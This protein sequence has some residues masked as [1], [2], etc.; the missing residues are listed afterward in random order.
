[1]GKKV[2]YLETARMGGKST[3]AKVAYSDAPAN[4]DDDEL[5]ELVRAVIS[6]YGE[7][8]MTRALRVSA[9][10]EKLLKE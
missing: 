6:A 3:I 4:V 8:P 7:S 2:V 5:P 1:M 9:E 10:I